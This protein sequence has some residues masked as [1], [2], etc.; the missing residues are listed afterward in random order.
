MH[1]LNLLS[2]WNILNVKHLMNL[3]IHLKCLSKY[4]FVLFSI[5]TIIMLHMIPPQL[6]NGVFWS[7]ITYV[8]LYS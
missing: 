4:T 1:Q 8:Y 5:V 6:Q 3:N 2:K 7:F